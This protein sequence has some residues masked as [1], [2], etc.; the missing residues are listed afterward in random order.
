MTALDDLRTAAI[1]ELDDL[2]HEAAQPTCIAVVDAILD[3]A[4]ELAREELANAVGRIEVDAKRD[5]EKRAWDGYAAAF[6][7]MVDPDTDAGPFGVAHDA[8]VYADHL[9][10]ERRKRWGTP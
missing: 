9:L 3:A 6:V 4:R 8:A 1:R 2:T 5:D 7:A 10:V